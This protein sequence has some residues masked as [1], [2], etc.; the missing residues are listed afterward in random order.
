MKKR[1][2][3]AAA[4]LGAA[5]AAAVFSIVFFRP[6]AVRIACVGDSI[7]WGAYLKNRSRECYPARLQQ[8]LG[9]S[10]LV[11][12][13]G[14]NSATV[15]SS[16][17]KPYREQPAFERSA[18]FSPNVVFLMLGTN[19]TK[20]GNWKDI[21]SFCRDY[22]KLIDFYLALPSSR[23]LYILTPPPLFSLEKDGAIRFAM[24]REYLNLEIA[25]LKDIAEERNI[26]LIDIH[27]ALLGQEQFF[28]LDGVHPDCGGAQLIAETVCREFRAFEQNFTDQPG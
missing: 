11:K 21:D 22:E 10:Y 20:K 25:L 19:D 28:T 12:N 5:C 17:D 9:N 4:C 8:L 6:K 1:T 15:Q 7:T 18:A 26:P 14:V 3:F 27:E 2:F 23:R 13:F 24:H 16:G